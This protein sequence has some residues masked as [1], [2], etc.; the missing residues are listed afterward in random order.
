MI[1]FF[2]LKIKF[3]QKS[4]SKQTVF[5]RD[6]FSNIKKEVRKEIEIQNSFKK[7]LKVIQLTLSTKMSNS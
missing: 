3:V 1:Y 5:L 6:N 4:F 2:T 7:V